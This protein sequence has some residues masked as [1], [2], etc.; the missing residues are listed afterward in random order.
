MRRILRW[1]RLALEE[2]ASI[3]S[4]ARQA[5]A[6]MAHGAPLELVARTQRASLDEVRHAHAA[7]A[8][9]RRFAGSELALGAIPLARVD[10]PRDLAAL[11]VETFVDGCLGE[12]LAT[13][14]AVRARQRATD[15]DVI[16][17]LDDV[18]RD[19]TRHAALA[20]ATVAWAIRA[21][22]PSVADAG[23]AAWRA[24]SPP[25]PRCDHPE[26]LAGF[27]A[28][29]AAKER[30]ALADARAAVLEPAVAALL[31]L[32][33]RTDRSHRAVD[34]IEPPTPPAPPCSCPLAAPGPRV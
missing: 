29:S 14:V 20:W 15:P 10:L 22:G 12:T 18:I 24:W 16:A 31:G 1:L 33:E 6:L 26:R 34:R 3:A 11:A 32:L 21:G 25:A 23:E 28:W 19:E 2:H 30:A 27:G 13:A 17:A 4:F 7:L 5:L 9:A 8:L